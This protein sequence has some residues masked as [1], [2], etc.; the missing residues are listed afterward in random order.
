MARSR[1]GAR[2]DG[3]GASAADDGASP[4]KVSRTERLVRRAGL[5]ARDGE[6]HGAGAAV[7]MDD[8]ATAT[9]AEKDAG[10]PV[11]AGLRAEVA[12]VLGAPVPEARVHQDETAQVG[13]AAIEARAFAHGRD[14]FLGPGES[15]NDRA[16]MAHELTHVAQ[17]SGAAAATQAKLEVGAA[18]TP[19]EQQADA[20]AAQVVAGKGTT[21]LIVDD[22]VAELAPGQMRK[23]DFLARLGPA[24]EA[25]A[26]EE[27]GPLWSAA[28]CPYIEKYLAAYRARPA[29]DG[30]AF[31]RRF[32]QSSAAT[33]AELVPALIARVRI[34]VRHWREHGTVP[35]EVAAADPGAAAT[36]QAAA[37]A[38]PLAQA[39]PADEGRAVDPRIAEAARDTF[40]V[41]V[42]GARVHTGAAADRLARDHDALAVT[43]GK[44]V[45]FR[46]GAYQ[47]G[48][49]AGDALIA[50]ELA[51]TAQQDEAG[52]DESASGRDGEEAEEAGA[53][54]AAAGVVA[55][56]WSGVRSVVQR[57]PAR[58][59][60]VALRRCGNPPDTTPARQM[61]KVRYAAIETQLQGL[62]AQK[63][64][65]VDGTGTGDMATIEA[66]IDTL[67]DELRRDF[68]VRVDKGEILARID[69]GKDLLVIDGR[70][71]V[72]PTG[73]HYIGERMKFQAELDHIPPGE[74]LEVAWRW[75]DK[76][77][78]YGDGYRFLVNGPGFQKRTTALAMELDTPF[79]GL[80]PDKV[81][82]EK[83][84][85]VVAHIYVGG[86]KT[87]EI[88]SGWIPLSNHVPDKLEIVGAP[89]RIV[90]GAHIDMGIGPW[91]PD[92][93]HH[94]IDWFV[95]DVQV[96]TDRLGMRHKFGAA[97]THKVRADVYQVERNFGIDKAT[98]LKSASTSVEVLEAQAYGDAFLDDAEKSPLTPKPVGLKE[99]VASGNLS[100]AEIQRHIDRGGTEKPYWEERKKAQEERLAKIQSFAPGLDGMQP[101]PADPAAVKPGTSYSGPITAVLVMPSGGGAQPLTVHL[102]IS[103]QAGTWTARI[104]DSTSKKVLK[105]DGTG[106]SAMAAYEKVFDDWKA[107]NPYPTGG[108]IAHRFAPSGWSKGN[109]F[110]TYTTWKRAKE[111]VDGI[112]MVGGLVVGAL[113]LAAP[114]ATI[115]K[116]LGAALVAAVIARSSV[117]IYERLDSGGDL[118][119]TENILDGIAI[120]TSVFGITGTVLR[121][122]GLKTVSPMVYRV[123][124]YMIMASLAGDAGT[125]VYAT[126]E[127]IAALRAIEADPT[128]DESQKAAEMMR[129]MAS[130][131][132]SAA[133]MVVSNRELLKKGLKPNDFIKSEIPTGAKSELDI[134]ARLDAEYELKQAGKWSKDTSKL[135]DDALL[136]QVFT[137]RAVQEIAGK[138]GKVAKPA[139]VKLLIG[140]LGD[141]AFLKLASELG[142]GPLGALIEAHGGAKVGDALNRLAPSQMGKLVKAAGPGGLDGLLAGFDAVT[143]QRGGGGAAGDA[144]YQWG[145]TGK[146]EQA[147]RKLG[148]RVEKS[149]DPSGGRRLVVKTD[150]G[151]VEFVER[152]RYADVRIDPSKLGD[153]DARALD[154]LYADYGINDPAVRARVLE[155]IEAAR[156]QNP[157]LKIDA[158]IK[159]QVRPV[160]DKV[161]AEAGRSSTTTEAML[162]AQGKVPITDPADA[163]LL[164]EAQKL[165]GGGSILKDPQFQAART[166]PEA[167][168]MLSE[169]LKLA[170]SD[171]RAGELGLSGGQSMRRI[172]FR[173]D[174]FKNASG[175]D[176]HVDGAGK[177]ITNTDV[178][179]DIDVAYVIPGAGGEQTI[180]Y[181][182]SV[183][184]VDGKGTKAQA[185]AAL[186]NVRARDAIQAGSNRF[187]TK[188]RAGDDVFAEVK[189]VSGLDS[190]GNEVDLTGKLRWTTT[191]TAETV[192]S[193]NTSGFN[194]TLPVS[195]KEL[196]K[197]ANLVWRSIEVGSR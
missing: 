137:N 19:A 122:V 161:K 158:A 68:G 117:A 27:L 108:R 49:P 141:D 34:G 63:R 76:S 53:D 148:K 101:L 52:P 74:T 8:V 66:E 171:S 145:G 119:S 187:A 188:T 182:G 84:L 17:Q 164:A 51:H 91:T 169:R 111:W 189:H 185:D 3:G 93:A 156:L 123:G 45:A 69:K 196:D 191:T 100:L 42:G 59:P 162:Q 65:L 87:R 55:R 184:I 146:L 105:Y 180:G 47:P 23:R 140:K 104:I 136:D 77:R 30:E 56:L 90:E 128:L 35:P 174:L 103:E 60:G 20:V 121:T 127:A 22:D 181:V 67:I 125:F 88:T 79:W 115:T 144:S 54:Q 173:G 16:L 94:K 14:I 106:G 114:E 160:L 48:T 26:G 176:P 61:D 149:A 75:H 129:I 107:D 124:N 92:H 95:D 37:S 72:S 150:D 195:A 138:V 64:A 177:P 97:G 21:A 86:K 102:T 112:I 46:S 139:E 31:V 163:V 32:T 179:P 6:A 133:L 58:R 99:T 96:G 167:R 24:L 154:K 109:G 83:G 25:A 118:F 78:S 7:T 9:V 165:I 135:S 44:D 38:G 120:V 41:D 18:G 4:G 70:V 151:P 190:A 166:L 197:L 132:A 81:K 157:A 168:D 80:L 183:K 172:Q 62:L 143:V 39:L 194:K 82:S 192:G 193:S 113:L 57:A 40:G 159:S 5:E 116:V 50:H 131:F 85:E 43:V 126:S 178:V 12:A 155:L 152:G 28:G 147:L 15:A 11:D 33:A 170:H 29:S 175:P 130:L 110:E 186:Q 89:A 98:Y 1:R 36:A 2:S 71:L 13:T 134:G 10:T 73:Q 142:E 153:A